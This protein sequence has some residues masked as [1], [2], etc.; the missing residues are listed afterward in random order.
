M[1]LLRVSVSVGVFAWTTSALGSFT[2]VQMNQL[3][4]DFRAFQACPPT[5]TPGGTSLALGGT[6]GY[7]PP[8]TDGSLSWVNDAIHYQ[9]GTTMIH[10]PSGDIEE[11]ERHLWESHFGDSLNG[12]LS[13]YYYKAID[14]DGINPS[15]GTVAPGVCFHAADINVSYTRGPNDPANLAWVQIIETSQSAGG[16]PNG[17][18]YVDPYPNDGGDDAPFYFNENDNPDTFV[19][20]VPVGAD[21]VFGDI[22]NRNHPDATPYSVWWRAN[23]FLASWDND[24]PNNLT[25]HDGIR[26]GFDGECVPAPGAL[27]GLALAGLFAARRRRGRAA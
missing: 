10:R 6:V 26:W 12:A 17:T 4:L 8:T 1:R 25:L 15:R 20:R 18:P 5:V 14:Q 27:A 9:F 13:V 11:P 22:P 19:H 23:L 21:M 2:L 16:L 3:S 24:S 7:W